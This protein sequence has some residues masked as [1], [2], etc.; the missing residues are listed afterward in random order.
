M[1]RTCVAVLALVLARGALAAEG[2]LNVGSGVHYSSGKYGG[3]TTTTILA[4]PLT[5]RYDAGAWTFKANVPWLRISGENAV[6]PGV[7][8]I[9]G[10][11]RRGRAGDRS[12]VSGIGDSSVSATYNL[13]GTGAISGIGLS[14][15]VKL[16][17][18][19]EERGLGTGSTDLAFQLDAYRELGPRTIFGVVGYTVFGDSPLGQFENVANAGIGMSQKIAGGDTIGVALDVR[20]TGNPAPAPQRELTGFW[21]H[22]LDRSWRTQA[23]LLKGFADGSPDWGAGMSISYAF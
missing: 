20:Q 3:S 15:K 6:V 9:E 14:G 11:A 12:S 17:T 21:S 5:A 8:R 1:M 19:D 10:G 16:P 18:G 23:Y 22:R 13:P 4:I 2:E 7:G